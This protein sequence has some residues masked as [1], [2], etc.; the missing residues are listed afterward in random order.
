VREECIAAAHDTQGR[1]RTTLALEHEIGLLGRDAEGRQRGLD[2]SRTEQAHLLGTL[3]SLARNPPE[4]STFVPGGAIA[5]SRGEL[6]LQATLPALRAEAHALSSEIER[7]ASLR[8]QVAAKKG[9][10]ASTR[11]ALEADRSHLAELTAHRLELSRHIRPQETGADA[12]IAAL[13]REASDVG[14]LI[15]RADAAIERH[16]KEVLASARAALPKE[17]AGALTA[18]TPDPTRPRELHAFDPPGSVLVIPVAGAITRTFGAADPTS[19]AGET[20]QGLSLAALPGAEA[21]APFDGRVI[22]AGPFR[23]LGLVLIIR[24][25][26]LYHTLLAGLQR[27]DFKADQWVLAGEPVGAMPDT[28]GSALYFEVRRGDR[29][30]DPQPWLAPGDQ[31]RDQGREV[32]RDQPDED[33]KVRE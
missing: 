11:Q 8:E 9:E 5:R 31:G 30:V 20:S 24:H 19:A 32:G 21:V 28:P 3:A 17:K 13:G 22:Y 15:K 10:L 14:D 26:T 33:Q 23:D 29:P 25:G 2:E 4:Q 12:R 1:E 18:Q 7:I 16:D 6:L 27:V